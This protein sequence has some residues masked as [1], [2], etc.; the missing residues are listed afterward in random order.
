[1]YNGCKV[2][3]L[4]RQLSILVSDILLRLDTWRVLSV[5]LSLN[6]ACCWNG[7]GGFCTA[8]SDLD[9]ALGR[10]GSVAGYLFVCLSCNNVGSS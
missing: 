10:A 2:A 9:E 6:C 7:H 5:H 1:M 8:P 4:V 3:V